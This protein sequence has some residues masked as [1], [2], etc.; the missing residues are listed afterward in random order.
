MAFQ[1]RLRPLLRRAWRVLIYASWVS[2]CDT[3]P[4]QWD[5]GRLRLM[6]VAAARLQSPSVCKTRPLWKP[7]LIR[8]DG[9]RLFVASCSQATFAFDDAEPF[10]NCPAEGPEN[11]PITISPRY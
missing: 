8:G 1:R 4:L 11:V 9:S 10:E 5:F 6:A 2:S 3:H 7:I